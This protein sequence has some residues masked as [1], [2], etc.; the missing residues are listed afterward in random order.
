MIVEFAV[1][2][3]GCGGIRRSGGTLK[4]VRYI[5]LKD[6]SGLDGTNVDED[7]PH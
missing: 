4:H 6:A 2:I 5:G 3:I 7:Y 1:H